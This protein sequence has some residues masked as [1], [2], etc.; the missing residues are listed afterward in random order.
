[1]ATESV[2]R[3]RP[4]KLGLCCPNRNEKWLATLPAGPTF[5]RWLA[6]SK[7]SG[8]IPFGSPITFS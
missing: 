4:L 1:M 3:K 8:S 7:I 5:V 6:P 2:A